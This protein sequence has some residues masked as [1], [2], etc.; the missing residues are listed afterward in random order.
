MT[1]LTS[2]DVRRLDRLSV[3]GRRIAPL[4]DWQG[5][6]TARMRGL[7]TEF[8]DFRPYHPGDDPRAIDWN[9]H[10]RLRQLVV[11][12]PSADAHLA[13]HLLVD[14][15]ASMGL[16]SPS[17]LAVALR[18]AAALAY[19]ALAGRDAVA[20]STFDARVQPLAPS[21][22]GPAQ[23]RRITEALAT[24]HASGASSAGQALGA[25]AGAV[26]GPGLA[27]VISD[28][29]DGDGPDAGLRALRRSG[30][31]AG[32]VRITD[33]EEERIALDGEVELIDSEA[34]D[35]TL[36]VDANAIAFYRRQLDEV[37][38]RVADQCAQAGAPY[39]E[40]HTADSFTDVLQACVG[41]GLLEQRGSA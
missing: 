32:A 8:H 5:G 25:Y 40:V 26:R 17:K 41:S 21:G 22:L 36:L 29:L 14:T 38:R 28:F 24:L 34:P 33:R 37:G 39:L 13:V 20:V 27:I 7:G 15:S 1:L 18:V 12:V 10:A 35:Q 16:G 2:E 23:G 9:I 3:A 4:P 11:R 6:R 31:T 19:T 30:L